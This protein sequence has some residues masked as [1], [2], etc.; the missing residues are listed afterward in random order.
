MVSPIAMRIRGASYDLVRFN[1]GLTADVLQTVSGTASGT[2]GV[3]DFFG[4][5]AIRVG[6]NIFFIGEDTLYRSVNNGTPSVEIA[7]LTGF[8][9]SAS[10][11]RWGHLF[12]YEDPTDGP[13]IGLM[14]T[15]PSAATFYKYVISTDTWD[16]GTA[17]GA[18]TIY[19]S[20]FW[21]FSP[22]VV[23]NKL[24][25]ISTHR[26]YTFDPVALSVSVYTPGPTNGNFVLCPFNNIVY[27]IA[28]GATGSPLEFGTFTGG[29]FAKLSDITN[30]ETPAT[31]GG[32][33]A[34]YRVGTDLYMCACNE[35]STD[36]GWVAGKWDGTTYTEVTSTLL[37]AALQSGGSFAANS[38]GRRAMPFK[39]LTKSGTRQFIAVTLD[40]I[41]DVS[42]LYEHVGSTWQLVNQSDW[43]WY[44]SQ[45]YNHEA[46][47]ITYWNQD[48]LSVTL[49]ESPAVVDGGLQLEFTAEGDSGNDDKYVAI[50]YREL[51][52]VWTQA[53]LL[54]P[55]GGI[56]G[57][58]TLVG[59]TQIANLDADDLTTYTIIHDFGAD[60]LSSNIDIEY[61]AL[62]SKTTF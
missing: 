34:L 45:I 37:P 38:R 50:F 17:I 43:S 30:S 47:G 35:S 31:A 42:I 15:E 12:E 1:N 61:K 16:G 54:A 9:G 58:A 40:E 4:C 6:E 51:D 46:S 21:F 22:C 33:P 2:L 56:G 8:T 19:T 20:T 32:I 39:V 60:G 18:G 23:G 53:S 36:D 26:V 7:S 49:F 10:A 62:I 41:S 13:C 28:P 52:G 24:Y 11:L 44:F 48:D 27:M 14:T 57:S 5:R 55:S 59:T 3:S 25:Y 29:V